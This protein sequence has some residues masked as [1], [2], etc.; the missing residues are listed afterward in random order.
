MRAP[1]SLGCKLTINGDK[2]IPRGEESIVQSVKALRE[3]LNRMVNEHYATP[4][5]VRFYSFPLTL[6]R[7]KIM[8]T[9]QLH[10]NMNRR[11]CWGYVQGSAPPD[12]KKLIWEHEKDELFSDPRFGG[13]H[14]TASLRKAMRLTGF[15]PEELYR[16][17]LIPGCKAAFC[18]WLQLA[19]DSFWL[20]ALSASTILERANNNRIVEGG[21]VSIRDYRRY[22]DE[23]LKLLADIPGHNVHNVADEDHSDMMEEVLDRHALTEEAQRHVLEG[24]RDS[25]DF[26]RA[27]RGALGVFL[28]TIQ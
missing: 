24:A 3:T 13:D 28:E 20:K 17:E 9:Q 23:L 16:A 19:R 12:I 4:E 26:D 11:S 27:Y 6:A 7:G 5:M 14:H 2:K 10:F 22:T 18:A 1:R 25:L 8:L 21:G 15:Q